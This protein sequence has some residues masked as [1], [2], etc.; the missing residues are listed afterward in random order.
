M[1]SQLLIDGNAVNDPAEVINI[2]NKITNRLINFNMGMGSNDAR[3]FDALHLDLEPQGLAA[4]ATPVAKRA[5]LTDLLNA[6]L[7]IRAH[8][9][10]AGF[11]A[12]PI[13][14]DIPFFFDK[15]PVD[16]GSVDWADATDRDN[17]FAAVNA[18]LDGVSIMTFS[19]DNA[20]ALE[21]ATA[22]ERGAIPDN[23]R[24][25]I[26]PKIGPTHLWLN[27]TEFNVALHELEGDLPST[28]CT[29]IENYAFWRHAHATT[30]A[31]IYYHHRGTWMRT[32]SFLPDGS[33]IALGAI[34][35]VGNPVKEDEAISFFQEYHVRRLYGEYND[36]PTTEAAVVAFWNTKLHN[37]CIQSQ[38]LLTGTAVNSPAFITS[39]K[40]NL[41]DNLVAFNNALGADE[42]SKFDGVHLAL[43][44]QDLATFSTGSSA[45]RRALLED[46]L[47]A[48]I[49]LRA[50]LD[51]SNFRHMP[52]F[53][54]L[55]IDFDTLPIDGGAIGWADATDRNDWYAA[56]H[57]TV[58]GITVLPFDETTFANVDD[59][60]AYERA[61]AMKGKT[62]VALEPEHGPGTIWTDYDDF[63]ALL[64]DVES[65]YG[66]TV[67]TDLDD[68]GNWIFFEE[69]HDTGVPLG[70]GGVLTGLDIEFF[71][72]TTNPGTGTGVIHVAVTPGYRY[73]VQATS[74]LKQWFPLSVLST[75]TEQGPQSFDVPFQ[76]AA[77]TQFY[78]LEIIS[79]R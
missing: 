59:V 52:I 77:P 62:R 27:V 64:L 47:N 72:V 8:L 41:T 31:G 71:P 19:K 24:I 46:L 76:M 79:E 37:A 63:L 56:V 67:A 20:T 3:K 4:W 35:V 49:E 29:D 28:E 69:T 32:Y 74:D 12:M 13:Y 45:A 6:Y 44:P 51:A 17:W 5:L 78:R 26:Q 22:Y 60:T 10:T 50:H 21:V 54:D 11:T 65:A 66:A 16:G 1:Q 30:G 53:A 73:T 43:A 40:D 61:S 55:P 9:D 34:D 75:T 38:L 7:D 70:G 42:P 36:R 58:N 15:L 57:A 33:A 14:A 2:K 68:Y 48:Y 23:A 18:V 25:A 39:L